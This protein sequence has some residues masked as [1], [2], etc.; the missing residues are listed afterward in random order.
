MGL[1]ILLALA[2]CALLFLGIWGVT[3]TL[4]T[5][6]LAKNFPEDV[7]ARLQPR[8]DGLAMSPRRALG[9]VILALFILGYLGLFVLGGI[10][11]LRR[12]YG[13]GQFFLRFLIIGG[14][15]KAFDIIALDWFLL[16]KTRF[17][18]RYFPETEGCAGWQDFGYNRRQ[19][20]RQCVM[21]LIGSAL[22]AWI[23]TRMG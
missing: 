15:I 4:P 22:T 23:F 8:L 9:W 17:F 19:Q 13:Y 21:I 2:G 10:D 12:G 14:V 6:L 7:Q 3:V 20:A 5:K 1:T 16:T 11:G 18:Q